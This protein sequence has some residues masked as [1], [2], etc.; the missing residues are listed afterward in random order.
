MDQF[1]IRVAESYKTYLSEAKSFFQHHSAK[2][3]DNNHYEHNIEPNYWNFML[4]DVIKTSGKWSGKLAFEYGCGAGRNLLNL[5]ILGGFDRADGIDI[6][7]SNALNSKKFVESH[8]GFGRSITAE[9]NGFTCY[10]FQDDT[11]SFVMSHQVFIHIPNHEIRM[12]IYRD[13]FRILVRGGVFIVH[14]KTMGE[15]VGYYENYNR[16]PMNVSLVSGLP[17][18][19][20]FESIGF[21]DVSVREVV[22]YYDGNPEWFVRGV[23]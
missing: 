12:S 15:A 8:L 4:E 22:N 5:L 6:S 14:F 11:Y 10:P 21:G 19:K 16:F 18:M 7:K 23:K 20:D 13:I 1:Q 17:V 2:M 3:L 9:G